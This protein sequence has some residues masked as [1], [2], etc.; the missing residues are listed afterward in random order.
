MSDLKI[1]TKVTMGDLELQNRLVL[2]PL[3]RARYAFHQL[4]IL[5]LH[6]RFIHGSID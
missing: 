6:N 3:T 1:L 2:A 4:Q 5:D